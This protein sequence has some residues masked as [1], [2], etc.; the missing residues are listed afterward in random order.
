MKFASLVFATTA[1]ASA[2]NPSSAA[3]P[4]GIESFGIGE[5]YL[6]FT[7]GLP[8]VQASG[9]T[10]KPQGNSL[11]EA[12]CVSADEWKSKGQQCTLDCGISQ[13]LIGMHLI[14]L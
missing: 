13:L 12:V 1:A 7:C 14:L 9:L 8:C 11:S 10:I 6:I 4:D 2:I 5:L 3:K